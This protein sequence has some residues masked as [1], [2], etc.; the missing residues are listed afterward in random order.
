M[1]KK[2]IEFTL[3][4]SKLDGVAEMPSPA[5]KNLPEWYKNMFSYVGGKKSYDGG[6]VNLTLKKCIPVLDAIGSGYIIKT[7]TDVCFSG[8]EVTWSIDQIDSRAVEGHSLGQIEG[9]PL[10]S[11]YRKEPFKWCN[12]WHIKT[13]KGYSTLFL[14]PIGHHLPFKIIEGVVDTDIFPL[15]INFPFFLNNNFEGVIPYGTPMVQAIPFKRDSFKSKQG[16]FNK[17]N[18]TK[19]TNFHNKTFINKYKKNWWIRKEFK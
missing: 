17:E 4:D 15:T 12:P 11:Y 6:P 8:N 7:W 9:Y 18:Y 2:I 14:N 16:I 3:I 10:L 19:L 5:I 13:P 1:L